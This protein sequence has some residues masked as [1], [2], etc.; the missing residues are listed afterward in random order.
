[1]PDDEADDIRQILSE[2]QIKYYETTAGNWG[3]SMPA[4]WLE[5]ER[6]FVQAKELIDSYQAERSE[7][8]REVYETRKQAGEHETSQDR[9]KR[10]PVSYI[11]TIAFILFLLYIFIG[12]FVSIGK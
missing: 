2:H 5:D 10:D 7:R 6:Q 11:L 3:V 4:I 12:T 9:F 8:A 1:V